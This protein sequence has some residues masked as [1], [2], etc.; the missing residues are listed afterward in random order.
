MAC[1]SGLVG[2]AQTAQMIQRELPAGEQGLFGFLDNVVETCHD[3]K[4]DLLV[5]ALSERAKAYLSVY[6]K[7]RQ[8]AD[9]WTILQILAA[10]EAQLR[11]LLPEGGG[12]WWPS[13][14]RD[15]IRDRIVSAAT[16]REI[17][18]AFEHW[19]EPDYIA[20]MMTEVRIGMALDAAYAEDMSVPAGQQKRW[21]A[22]RAVLGKCKTVIE[23][24]PASQQP[25]ARAMLLRAVEFH[26]SGKY[27]RPA[28]AALHPP[29]EAF[30]QWLRVG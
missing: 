9:K 25:A 10:D 27:R 16:E 12:A 4:G 6:D 14:Y 24:L 19:F 29:V 7:A 18:I 1:N 13:M 15:I 2:D 23:A 8:P 30:S 22:Y 3:A 5:R 28:N 17:D 26:R 21:E 20:N 11:K